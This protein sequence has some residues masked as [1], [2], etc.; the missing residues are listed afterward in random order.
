ME[1]RSVAAGNRHMME[2]L[3]VMIPDVP[4]RYLGAGEAEIYVVVDVTPNILFSTPMAMR[5]PLRWMDRGCRRHQRIQSA[6]DS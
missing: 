4:D 2:K 1:G 6:S 5:L 3:Q